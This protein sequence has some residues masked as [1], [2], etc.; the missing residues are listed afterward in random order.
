MPSPAAGI[1]PGML[2][3]IGYQ[4]HNTAATLWAFTVSLLIVLAV[5]RHARHRR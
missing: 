1:R 5:G 4:S 3:I 2:A